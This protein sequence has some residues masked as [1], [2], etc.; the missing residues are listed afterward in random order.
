MCGITGLFEAGC[1]EEA[2]DER[3]RRMTGAIVH[4][5]PDSDGHW[6]D[7]EAGI[8]LGH[9]RLAIVDLTPTGYQPMP[10]ASGR[11]MIVFN[12]E[13][14]NFRELRSVLEGLGAKFETR[15]DTEVVLAAFR[16]WGVAC[17]ERLVGMFSLA[18]WDDAKQELFLARDRAGEKPLYYMHRPESFLFSSE[19]KALLADPSVSRSI[20]PE[21]LDFFLAYGYVPRD[22]CI[23]RGARKLPQGHALLWRRSNGAL[24]IWKYWDLPTPA[25]T[26]DSE[27][28]LLQELEH[29][30][31]ASVRRQLVADVPIGILLSGG[32][33][34]SLVTAMAARVSSSV[35]TFTIAF[36]GQG[37]FDESP[38]ARAVARHFGTEHVELAAEAASVDLLPRLA[39][40]YDEPLGDSSMVPTYLVSRLIREHA[41]VAL[42]GDGGDELFGGYDHYRWI[43][44]QALYQ[45]A[46]PVPVRNMAAVAARRFLPLGFRGRNYLIGGSEGVGRSMAHV[47]MF[48]D[49]ATRGELLGASI[50]IADPE[51]W[52]STMLD[53]REQSVLQRATAIDF[54]TYLP[55]DILAKVDR[56]SMLT[57]LEVRAPWLDPSIIEFAFGRVPDHLRATSTSLKVLPRLLARTILPPGLE[58]DRK[59]GFAIPLSAWFKGDWGTFMR[60]VLCDSSSTLFAPPVV[61]RLFR[62]QSRGLPNTQR[63]FALTVF[64]LWRR[65]YG[66]SL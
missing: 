30:L 60:Q 32:I 25:T 51:S 46:V 34:S 45:G 43:R 54:R 22:N 59:R 7:P 11:Y 55:D 40:Q 44:K 29:L 57:S 37:I 1:G 3:L 27:P 13:I 41:T 10:S 48:F 65:H 36:P 56:A 18:I 12:G 62:N 47:N 23:L 38:Q 5:G 61:A 66:M 4:R 8:A 64:E 50:G 24:K 9:R 49:R 17:V 42:G 33:D 63:L 52:K 39:A 14:Y 28:A 15:S 35:K 2:L 26:F 16:E 21:A 19:L 58:V 20:D 31:E 53:G 6:L